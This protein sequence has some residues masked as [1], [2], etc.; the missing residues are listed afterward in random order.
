MEAPPQSLQMFL[1]RLCWQMLAPPQ[2]LQLLLWRLCWQMLAPPQSLHLLLW[3]LCWQML[4]PPQSLQVLLRRLCG[5]IARAPQSLQALLWQFC[6]QMLAPPQSLQVLLM[7]ADTRKP[8]VLAFVPAASRC[9]LLV[10]PFCRAPPPSLP[11]PPSLLCCFRFTVLPC[12]PRPRPGG[13]QARWKG[14]QVQRVH[15]SAGVRCTGT[16][17]TRQ[18]K[19]PPYAGAESAESRGGG[20]GQ[21]ELTV[22]QLQTAETVC[23]FK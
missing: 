3:R 10:H 16:P 1:R 4:V 11:L 20:L 15:W 7:L 18:S 8:A 14:R 23:M 21:G 5:Q 13:A 19:A 22:G 12:F 6:W 9:S 17:H 2:S